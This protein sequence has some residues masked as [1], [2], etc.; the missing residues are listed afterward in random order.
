MVM[1]AFVA[2]TVAG[3]LLGR[4]L[5]GWLHPL[6]HWRFVLAIVALVGGAMAVVAA[7]MLPDPGHAPLGRRD[8][9]STIELLRR[10]DVTA[11][12]VTAFSAF[13]VFSSIFNYLPFR[14]QEPPLAASTSVV[15]ATYLTYVVGIAAGPLAGHWS[16]RFGGGTMIAAGTLLAT[17][18]I[19]LTLIASLLWVVAGLMLLCAGFFAIHAAAAGILNARVA[20]G[21]G[22]ANALYVMFYYVGGFLGI[23]ASGYAYE[24]VGWMGVIG[25]SVAALV[26]P[27]AIGLRE[28][29]KVGTEEIEF[30][31]T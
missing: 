1:G 28:N 10:A 16:Q 5:G 17:S 25:L 15:T 9:T 19:L 12:Y 30:P 2:A 24:R 11:M 13:F 4:L 14:L 26:L 22:R 21:K 27:L 18:G 7:A 20:S 3:G 8:R 31:P 23:T 29:R 6:F